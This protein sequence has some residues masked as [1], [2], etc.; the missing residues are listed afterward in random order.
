MTWAWDK[1]TIPHAITTT[2]TVLIAVA[3]LEFTPSMPTLANMEVN[4]GGCCI[5]WYNSLFL[6]FRQWELSQWHSLLIHEELEYTPKG[7]SYPIN[8]FYTNTVDLQQVKSL[9]INDYSDAYTMAGYLMSEDVEFYQVSE[10]LKNSL[11][12]HRAAP[13]GCVIIVP[14]S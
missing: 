5:S 14:C 1:N 11:L 7:G 9:G 2:T 10:G 13:P 6:I 4:D 12:A 3:R 8:V